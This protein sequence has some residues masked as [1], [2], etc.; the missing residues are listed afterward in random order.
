MDGSCL[1]IRPA[2]LRQFVTLA[3]AGSLGAA[4]DA[5]GTTPRALSRSVRELERVTGEPLLAGDTR[6]LRLSPAG[7]TL[8]HSAHRVLGAL[9]RFMAASRS[10]A[11]MLRVAHVPGTDTLSVVLDE[12]IGLRRTLRL[13]ERA[14]HEQQQLRDLIEH[15][16]DLA[17]C[18]LQGELPEQLESL[19]IRLDPLVVLGGCT[20]LSKPSDLRGQSVVVPAYGRSRPQHEQLLDRLEQA[21]GARV[22]RVE[23]AA[24][25]GQELA[26]LL[27]AA[28]G[29][30]VVLP[31]SSAGLAG[32]PVRRL[33]GPYA[34]TV[35]HA[36]WR[37]GDCSEEAGELIAAARR[38]AERRG[39]L[40][41]L[42]L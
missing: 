39:W 12:L 15:R 38:V 3:Q 8:A 9:E 40:T 21:S 41:P 36:I 16:L 28:R 23:I 10:D 30:L 24:G 37:S 22:E 1:D 11:K 35:W 19:P 4:A 17:F 26:A 6:D 33:A 7:E 31:S 34:H 2:Q 20:A 32:L 29:R 42:A 25:S 5:L 18:P 14:G 27:R 13:Q